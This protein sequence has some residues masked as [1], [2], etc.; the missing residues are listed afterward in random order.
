MLSS[1]ADLFI[2]LNPNKYPGFAFSWVILISH[3]QFMPHFLKGTQNSNSP[4]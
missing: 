2:S 4:I 1:L 3:K